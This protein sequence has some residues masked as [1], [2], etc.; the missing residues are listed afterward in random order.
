MK[1]DKFDRRVLL[2]ATLPIILRISLNLLAINETKAVYNQ[3]NSNEYI[4]YFTWLA[5]FVALIILLW[6]KLRV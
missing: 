3:L 6:Q 4:D 5:L 2:V 1:R